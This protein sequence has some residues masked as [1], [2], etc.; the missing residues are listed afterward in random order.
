M[1]NSVGG[2]NLNIDL[3][4][5]KQMPGYADDALTYITNAQNH[6]NAYNSAMSGSNFFRRVSSFY[7]TNIADGIGSS[8]SSAKNDTLAI[9]DN[10][11]SIVSLVTQFENGTYATDSLNLTADTVTDEA[12]AEVTGTEVGT[13]EENP[14]IWENILGFFVQ[15]GTELAK[16]I[17]GVAATFLDLVS[18]LLQGI[19][20]LVE[21]IV[22]A[23]VLLGGTLVAW[24]ASAIN[25]IFGTDIDVDAIKEWTQSFVATTWVDNWFHAFYTET[26]FGNWMA[27][28][29]I[30]YGT[31]VKEILVGTSKWI[32]I[33]AIGAVITFFTGSGGLG[34]Y[35]ALVAGIYGFGSGAELGYNYGLGYYAG[36]GVGLLKGG[37]DAVMGYFMGKSYQGVYDSFVSTIGKDVVQ[38]IPCQVGETIVAPDGTEVVWNG[39]AW[40]P[41]EAVN[42]GASVASETVTNAAGQSTKAFLTAGETVPLLQPN[43]LMVTG[44]E[45]AAL[46]TAGKTV[47]L[48]QPN[49]LMVI[50]QES[51]ALVPYTTSTAIGPYIGAGLENVVLNTV[52]KTTLTTVGETAL[53]TVGKTALTTAGKTALSTAVGAGVATAAGAATTAGLGTAIAGTVGTGVLEAAVKHNMPGMPTSTASSEVK[54]PTTTDVTPGVAV[55]PSSDDNYKTDTPEDKTIYVKEDNEEVNT[56]VEDTPIGNIPTGDY[57]YPSNPIVE[58]TP[59]VEPTPIVEPTP[60]G[61]REPNVTFVNVGPESIHISPTG[62]TANTSSDVVNPV[63]GEAPASGIETAN[64]EQS[65]PEYTTPDITLEEPNYIFE[66]MEPTVENPELENIMNSNSDVTLEEVSSSPIQSIEVTPLS[67]I[68]PSGITPEVTQSAPEMVA[69]SFSGSQAID[70]S[71]LGMG[72]TLFGTAASAT[73]ANIKS[74]KEENEKSEEFKQKVDSEKNKFEGFNQF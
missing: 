67:E 28:N 53:T 16:F 17:E 21:G 14:T 12:V 1:G 18:S 57:G 54:T 43:G 41:S 60:S 42:A 70:T 27:D 62:Y 39:S 24:G 73:Y 51:T 74:K 19:G 61:D 5:F 71:T 7:Y 45:S 56:Q 34:P 22:D 13:V 26:G 33:V 11:N 15:V 23:A 8:I 55:K 47:P 58:P 38:T 59:T 35:V 49:A 40:V 10:G 65:T 63:I 31:A 4:I 46:L 48:L 52:G 2:S 72:G 69:D 66:S 20:E 50:G 44:Q 37:I 9:R 3:D 64:I 30:I 32:G 6:L 68:S 25:F 29:S 36:A